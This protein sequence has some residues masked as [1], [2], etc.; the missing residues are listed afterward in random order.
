MALF[1]DEEAS[2]A[3]AKIGFMGQAG[4]GKTHTA[5]T[6]AI[7]LVKHMRE[8][9]VVGADKPVFLLDTEKGAAWIRPMFQEAGIKLLVEDK[10]RAF[11]D[12]VPSM[13]MAEDKG[14]ILII[15][16]ITHFWAELQTTYMATRKRSKPEF[17]DWA[18]M[19]GMWRQFTDAYVNNSLHCLLCGRL[20]YEYEDSKDENGR[21]Q[22]EKTGVKMK[23][24]GEL[25]YEPSMLVWME[26]DMNLDTGQ[27][28]RTATILKDRSRRLDGKKLINPTFQSF[29]PHVDFLQLGA[30]H[31]GIDTERTSA[32]DIPDE[33]RMGDQRHIRREIVLEE[34]EAILVKHY[35]ST[36]TADKQAKAALIVKHF[37]TPSWTEISR[38]MPL[39]DLQSSFDALHVELTGKASHYDKS[40][41]APT[42]DEIPSFDT[43]APVVADAA[44][45]VPAD[46]PPPTVAATPPLVD[47]PSPAVVEAAHDPEPEVIE[48]SEIVAQDIERMMRR[49]GNLTRLNEVWRLSETD[50][51]QLDPEL[52]ARVFAAYH[53]QKKRV[54]DL[55]AKAKVA[56]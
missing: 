43:P 36:G 15:D 49:T 48:D 12:L 34:I 18:V 46:A 31:R 25:G 51:K 10:T 28:T 30:D 39:A 23:A 17:Q 13:R 5:A 42:D 16:S 54:L 14:A 2:A 56:A 3:Y 11:K 26:R 47:T 7:G 29:M 41:P 22:I 37:K 35:P 44:L 32:S 38:L 33:P 1:A 40:G 52:Q 9:G 4:S 6:F 8:R 55:K 45:A 24:E 53:V 20:G 19:K 21:R 27:T 50:F